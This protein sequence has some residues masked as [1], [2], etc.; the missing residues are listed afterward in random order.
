[1]VPFALVVWALSVSAAPPA[2][3]VL[4]PEL[5]ARVERLKQDVEREPTSLSNFAERAGVL[6]E[7]ANAFAV[8]GGVIPND[9]PLL[10]R[11]ARSL[12][13]PDVKGLSEYAGA[14]D[15]FVDEL[16]VKE[17]IPGALGTLELDRRE[18]LVAE[19]WVTFRQTWTVG[20]LPMREGGAI[21]LGRDGFNNH[22]TPQVDDPAGDNYIAI[23]SSNPDAR[24]VHRGIGLRQT[25]VTRILGIFQLEGADLRAG[26]TVTITYGDTSGGSRGFRTQSSSVSSCTF[27]V[28]LA[29]ERGAGFMQPGWPGVEVVGKRDVSAVTVLAPSIVEPGEPFSVTVRSE[30]DRYNRA[31]GPSPPYQVR[32]NGE[33]HSQIPAGG[34][35]FVRLEGMTI[36]APGVYRWSVE[37]ADGRIS[38][39]GNP[40]WVRKNPPYRIYWGDTHG[41]IA[42]AD[43]QGTPEGFFE[44][45]RDD[46][47]LDFVTL[48]EHALWTDD[49]E[50]RTLQEMIPKYLEPGVFVPILGYEWTVQMPG[51]HHNI[52]YRNPWS[53]R[54]G[55]QVEWRLPDLYRELRRR[56][57]VDDVLSIP[58]AHQ[59]GNW[60]VSDPDI[61]RLVEITSTHGTFEFFGNRYLSQGWEVGFIGSSDNHHEHPGLTDTGTTFHTELGGLAAVMA[62]EKTTDAL[63]SAL[64]HIRAYAT[65]SRRIILDARL[66]DAPMGTRLPAGNDR[67]LSC[68]VMGTA[69]IERIDVI[70]NGGVVY[71]KRYVSD[72]LVPDSWVRVGFFSSSEVSAYQPPRNYRIWKG[73]LEVDGA[74]L[75]QVLAQ[76]LENPFQESFERIGRNRV[77]FS[78]WTRGRLDGLA[79]ELEGVG[80]ETSIRIHV[81]AGASGYPRLE[82]EPVDLELSLAEVVDGRLVH[83]LAVTG[84][85]ADEIGSDSVS[86]QLFD[87]SDSLDQAFEY[88]DLGARE[89]GD[90]YYLRVTQ[91]DGEQAWSSPWWV[92]GA[93]PSAVDG[94][95]VE[96]E[97]P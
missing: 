17:E 97:G 57:R 70:K 87:P 31:S 51:G 34:E 40:M 89:D 38:G 86:L 90:Y 18:P 33:L 53:S 1:V 84:A 44:F 65:G 49:R 23:T 43:G 93:V 59:P 63:F 69:P 35:S 60:Q 83:E 55:S 19:D 22:G 12:D 78:I 82:T 61:E 20:Q 45:A 94:A 46:A 3:D 52:L 79:L 4:S 10:V 85:S 32:L 37:T 74:T 68:R 91:I 72:R 13:D 7:W 48:S 76:G 24:F 95:G 16:R 21:Y 47:R 54:V 67:S 88:A 50:W 15:A 41:H 66:N 29:F 39:T 5:R 77:E 56:A 28:Y 14:L 8:A 30:D 6:W 9:L 36:D 26:D 25:L 71:Q 42:Y 62:K 81:D 73:W 64:R 75:K 92:G 2:D 96:G 11:A 27:P 80:P 58:H